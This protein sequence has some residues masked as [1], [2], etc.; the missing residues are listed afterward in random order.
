MKT[1]A[2]DRP[3]L[4]YLIALS[5]FWAAVLL[6]AA[7]WFLGA[8]SAGYALP[9]IAITAVLGFTWQQSNARARRR[10]A[11]LDAYAEREISRAAART[12]QRRAKRRLATAGI[13]DKP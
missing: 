1:K 13:L 12:A 7:I 6:I 2:A 10:Q 8:D 3:R 11:V 5:A 9:G 4:M